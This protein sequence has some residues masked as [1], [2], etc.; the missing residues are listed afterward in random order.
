MHRGRALVLPLLLVL[1]LS[2]TAVAQTTRAD[3]IAA[4]QAEKARQ[5]GTEGP[6]DAEVV[7]SASCDRPS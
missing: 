2:S 5:L 6:S 1:W 3:S 7:S 4:Q